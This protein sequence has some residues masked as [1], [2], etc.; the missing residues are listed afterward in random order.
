MAYG[1]GGYGGYGS[2]FL[3]D[4][5]G[6]D[7]QIAALQAQQ[8]GMPQGAFTKK[9]EIDDQ[10]NKLKSR[11]GNLQHASNITYGAQNGG[12]TWDGFLGAIVGNYL[13][14]YFRRGAEKSGGRNPYPALPE[15]V[16]TDP[17]SGVVTDRRDGNIGVYKNRDAFEN[18][19]L[20]N[21][22]P[23]AGDAM[24][25]LAQQYKQQALG[26]AQVPSWA[27]DEGLINHVL[28]NIGA[29][30]GAQ[31]AATQLPDWAANLNIEDI[32]DFLPGLG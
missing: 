8:A 7:N 29:E 10:I 1:Y 24:A 2:Q 6:I 17:K 23:A 20:Q 22:D 28:G 4:M 18:R 27:T 11:R 5:K 19:L 26:G 31:V 30:A 9:N 25:N 16:S 14:N 3:Q 15:D 32:K 12:N 13:G 21:Y